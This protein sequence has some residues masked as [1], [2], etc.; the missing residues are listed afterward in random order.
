MTDNDIELENNYDSESDAI[1]ILKGEILEFF[2]RR[3]ELLNL[4]VRELGEKSGVSY[5]VIYDLE[6]RCI[7]PKMETI[8]KIAH[9]LGFEVKI[10]KSYN[11]ANP[12][13][14]LTFFLPQRNDKKPLREPKLLGKV[15]L[16]TKEDKLRQ[17]LN[18]KGLYPDE[19]KEIE[20]YIAFK[21]SKH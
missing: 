5:T 21:L 7:L 4:T 3:R 13:F 16:N 14:A 9:A 20:S 15:T 18:L 2:K 8:V 12:I 17:I 10:S 19:I 1:Q 6:K 11:E